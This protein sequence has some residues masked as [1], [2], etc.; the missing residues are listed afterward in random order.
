MNKSNLSILRIV[1]GIL[2]SILICPLMFIISW[3]VGNIWTIDNEVL[4]KKYIIE[5]FD[6][7]D[8]YNKL[9]DVA[10]ES[11]TDR[12]EDTKIIEKIATEVF[13]KECIDEIFEQIMD[14]IFEGKKIDI[15]L[16]DK[17]ENSIRRAVVNV[18]NDEAENVI[19]TYAK[20]MAQELNGSIKDALEEI[21]NSQE[22]NKY[23]DVIIFIKKNAGT[24]IIAAIVFWGICWL[25]LLLIFKAGRAGF[26]VPAVSLILS[27]I[28][29]F[30]EFVFILWMTGEITDYV[31]EL[32]DGIEVLAVEFIVCF[33]DSVK[34]AVF[35]CGAVTFVAAIVM[36]IVGYILH[37]V[38][39]KRLQRL[40]QL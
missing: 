26:I 31:S 15:D 1:L 22:L 32:L 25:I 3:G 23:S 13:D 17:L 24:A 28:V 27:A 8:G 40:E 5:K 11:A 33:I 4:N 14:R 39:Q 37:T 10:I 29:F 38:R 30:A 12:I 34:N 20:D 6:E 35:M 9:I 19:D 2:L 7:I 36:I 18:Y 21:E 16:E